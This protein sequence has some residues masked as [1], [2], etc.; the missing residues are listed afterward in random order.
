[1]VYLMQAGVNVRTCKVYLVYDR[2]YL[3]V[4]VHCHV[5]VRKRLGL[6]PLR[7]IY[8]KKCS[9]AGTYG[10]G[11]LIREVNM[12]RSVYKI[13]FVEIPVLGCIRNGHGLA[14]YGYATLALYVHVV[15]NLRL[16]WTS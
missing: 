15:Q 1:M 16:G 11:D 3:K 10:A 12:A 6:Y 4:V 7:G 8:E 13:E 2:Y 5:E 14:L 9:F